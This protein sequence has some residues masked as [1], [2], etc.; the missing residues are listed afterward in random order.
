GVRQVV[1]IFW[2]MTKD[3]EVAGDKV[4]A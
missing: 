1:E 2:Q 3:K 4:N